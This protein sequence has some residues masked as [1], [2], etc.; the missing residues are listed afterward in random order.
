MSAESDRRRTQFFARLGN[1]R[2][3][4]DHCRLGHANPDLGRRE[5]AATLSATSAGGL[6][7]SNGAFTDQLAFKFSE[8]G[9][10]IK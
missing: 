7:A 2:V 3:A 6:E 9:K 8:G 4:I 1:D 5:S 10:E